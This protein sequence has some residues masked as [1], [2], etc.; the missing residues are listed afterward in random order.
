MVNLVL[1]RTE[2]RR[3]SGLGE[4]A[5]SRPID[6]M[7]VRNIGITAHIDA[8]KTTVTER[9][10]FYTG[11]THRL[12]EVDEGSA[13]M[14]WMEQEM[15]RGITITSAATTC[16]WR[17]HWI[18]II[19]TPG[20]VDFTVEVERSLRVLDGVVAVFCAVGGVQPQSETVWRQADRY[21]IPR[22]A[23][24]N[25]M[26]RN[27]ADFHHVLHEVRER[28]G[29]NVAAVQIPVGAE[30]QFEGIID[31]IEMRQW[32]YLDDLGT[33]MEEGSICED[34]EETAYVFRES[35][36]EAVAET[37]DRLME[38][39]LEGAPVSPEELRAALRAATISSAIVPVLCGAALKNRGVQLLLDAVLDFLPS[40]LDIP[41]VVGEHPRGGR[42]ERRPSDD[43]PFSAL[44]FK[45]ATDP[46]VGQLAYLRVYSGHLTAGGT[47]LNSRRDRKI[48]MAR[49]VR[50]HAN[51]RDEVD[52][53][54]T[55]DIVA[56]VGLK[57]T[58]TGDTLC[59]PKH[60]VLLESIQF[61]EPVI[62][63]AIEPKTKA[64]EEKLGMA[65]SRLEAEDPT[66]R[67]RV[68][69]ETGQVIVLGMGELHLDIIRDR[70]QREFHVSTQ[71]GA[72]QVAYHEAI[73]KS[74]R[75]EGRYV[76]QTGGRGQYGHVIVE[77]EPLP[78]AMG[79][80]F[81]DEIVGGTIPRNFIPAAREGCRAA[82]EVGILAGYSVTGVRVRLRDGSYHEV[83]SSDVAF[84]IA[85]SMAVHAAMEK[86]AP[87]LM[88]PI[89]LI[90]ITTPD[91]YL[92][93]VMA[94]L[95]SRR[96]HIEHMHLTA[97][98]SRCIRGL[99]PLAEM[100]GYA[101]ALRSLT[102]GRATYTMEPHSYQPVPAKIMEELASRGG[103]A[104]AGVH[105]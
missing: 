73:T 62:S 52:E 46:Y 38:K 9:V 102:Q 94:D 61:P 72:P 11:R 76:R 55:G 81:V 83:D 86:A 23:F 90:E 59:D 101:T 69:S 4:T 29:A 49:I 2:P 8:G 33:R 77:I 43:E 84:K 28:L 48:R 54:F 68:D 65:L 26:D 56:A 51:R 80:E 88:E 82:T 45:V 40:P 17:D 1:E 15:E 95:N 85:G 66:F 42:A 37:N 22:I 41:A 16:Q 19:D 36:L 24:V 99:V 44:V 13:T 35:L 91:D 63:A 57:D 58:E 30:D 79:F 47:V 14:D 3:E 50:M 93:D 67:V 21:S 18:N 20:H 31:L 96:G 100:F 25:K 34:Y 5:V 97:G 39:Y 98:G 89:M 103:G 6:L 78:D 105:A 71:L 92:G 53:V 27:G 32:T 70:L 12:G 75:G 104:L 87:T 60:P 10:L 7:R 64:D 74:A